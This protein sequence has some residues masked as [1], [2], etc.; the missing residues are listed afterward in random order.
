[1]SLNRSSVALKK[2][3]PNLWLCW[4]AAFSVCACGGSMAAAPPRPSQSP[5]QKATLAV[6]GQQRTYLMFRPTSLDPHQAAPLVLAL[7]GYFD[8]ALGMELTTSL[9]DQAASSGF[10]V[11]YPEGIYQSWNAGNC[12]G[13]AQSR[14]V[15]D[16]SFI[17]QLINRL[18][19][20]GH[21]DP[22]RVFVTGLSNGGMMAHRLAC[23]LSDRIAAVASV[24]GALVT[25]ACNPAR[26][27]SI[28]EIHGTKD[29]IVPF[30]GGVAVGAT[31]IP[32]MTS[33]MAR[34]AGIDGCSGGSRVTQSGTTKTTEWKTC[35]GGSVVVLDAVIGAGHEWFGQVG[36]LGEAQATRIVWD[37]FSHL[38]TRP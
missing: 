11:V 24:S 28:L 30:D 16:V 5:A 4:L 20:E 37:F 38:P 33:I 22:K 10:V 14:N 3:V 6:E 27:I 21:I 29:T 15:D 17:R 19:Q 2:W 35:R 9:D 18:V 12:C 34:W 1:M 23:E 25:A 13:D 26:P 7:H 31:S 32:P 8:D 36:V